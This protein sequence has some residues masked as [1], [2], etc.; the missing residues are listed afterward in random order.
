M[1][2]RNIFTVLCT[3]VLF[4][5]GFYT[6]SAH[7]YVS[8]HA[9]NTT[10]LNT[11]KSAAKTISSIES[12]H[13][14]NAPS[15]FYPRSSGSLNPLR[16]ENEHRFVSQLQHGGALTTTT[17][18]EIHT[19][20][21]EFSTIVGTIE[22]EHIDSINNNSEVPLYWFTPAN[23]ENHIL[24]QSINDPIDIEGV[25]VKASVQGFNNTEGMIGYVWPT[26]DSKT[27]AT[28]ASIKNTENLRHESRPD[29]LKLALVLV[30]YQNS[31]EVPFRVSQ[32]TEAIFNGQLNKY[33]HEQSY[34]TLNLKGDV[35]GWYT[36]N[37][38]EPATCPLTNPPTNVVADEG[39]DRGQYDL[40]M[41]L[42]QCDGV[43]TG[44]G[45][46]PT[47]D[48]GGVVSAVGIMSSEGALDPWSDLLGKPF[49]FL[50]RMVAHEIGHRIGK[51]YDL[52]YVSHSH[53][54]DCGSVLPFPPNNV[55]INVEYGNYYDMMGLGTLAT[56]FNGYLKSQ[57]GWIPD[58]N[59]ISID[60]SG[61]YSLRPFE[62]S[63]A[64]IA[65]IKLG[66]RYPYYLEYRVGKGFDKGS[67][68]GLYATYVSGDISSSLNSLSYLLDLHPDT[69]DWTNDAEDVALAY[70][71]T[72]NDTRNG[73]VID[74]LNRTSEDPEVL[75]FDVTLT[76][77]VGCDQN[78]YVYTT[79][80]VQDLD[81]HTIKAQLYIFNNNAFS[82]TNS[83]FTTSASYPDGFSLSGVINPF[84]MATAD[85]NMQWKS[86]T[87]TFTAPD[88]LPPGT[89][90]ITITVTNNMYPSSTA[91]TTINYV[92]QPTNVDDPTGI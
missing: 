40:L 80:P 27:I 81:L 73:V 13:I 12:T 74:N 34:D 22:R 86:G 8:E 89:Y 87:Y 66:T 71:D 84:S 7:G 61:T 75:N 21:R 24:V 1:K 35:Y 82:C 36:L 45:Y 25:S 76:D 2:N 59:V 28:H 79:T 38:D 85:P 6:V 41:M 5:V 62:K 19:V 10:T 18:E 15:S 43:N 31:E 83:T 44:S 52:G 91:T 53:G 54:Y 17:H 78:P 16:I 92:V 88:T 51:V 30:R 37:Q 72:F 65:R 60:H 14:D 4:L 69:S 23:S 47:S 55:C 56:H 39:I 46:A 67:S 3:I 42:I 57:L 11:W 64:Q 29:S 48:I 20:D 9:K 90:P 70:G 77:T 32:A 50:N 63:G 33:M 58:E 68:P 26:E 49:T